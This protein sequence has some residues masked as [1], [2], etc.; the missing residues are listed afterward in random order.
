MFGRLVNRTLEVAAPWAGA[1]VAGREPANMMPQRVSNHAAPVLPEVAAG[2]RDAMER[3][4]Q[5]YENLV[6][7]V[8]RRYL[9]AS[10]EAEDVVQEIFIELWRTAGRYDAA[11]ASESTFIMLIARRRLLDARRRLARQPVRAELD[12]IE[13]AAAP[14]NAETRLDDDAQQALLAL[15][16][17]PAE[18]QELLRLSLRDGL[19]HAEISAQTAL[20]LGTVKTAIRRGLLRLR[21]TLNLSTTP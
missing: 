6:W 2:N 12:A 10:P 5:R 1:A 14:A 3:C 15:Q 19:T 20:P 9:G 7:S 11:R 13:D 17:L 8:A 18:Q 21:Q 4:L 16:A